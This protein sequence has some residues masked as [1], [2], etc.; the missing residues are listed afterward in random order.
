MCKFQILF[1][2]FHSFFDQLAQRIRFPI[3]E[4]TELPGL[5][6]AEGQ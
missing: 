6:V 4:K 1:D 5:E 2:G 3:G